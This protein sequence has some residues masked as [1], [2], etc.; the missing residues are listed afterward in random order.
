MDTEIDTNNK[1]FI[2]ARRPNGLGDNL[3][4][5]ALC[6][7]L[8]KYQGKDLII[9][10]QKTA[11]HCHVF[12]DN[13]FP[14]VFNKSN[15]HGVQIFEPHDFPGVYE[16]Q[17]KPKYYNKYSAMMLKDFKFKNTLL[18]NKDYFAHAF[19]GKLKIKPE[20]QIDINEFYQKNL[21]N[22]YIISVHFRFGDHGSL[23]RR[24]T[25]KILN[26]SGKNTKRQIVENAVKLY[27]KKIDEIKKFHKDALVLIFT[28]CE[29]F[30][31]ILLEIYNCIDTASEYPKDGQ[32]F[33]ISKFKT[34]YEKIRESVYLTWLMKS[35]SDFLLYNQSNFNELPRLFIKNQIKIF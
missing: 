18:N 1:G 6:W 9:D 29:L 34:P 11:Y 21:L 7:Y 10:W 14:M 22:K 5:L 33:H 20:I 32:A 24:S 31:N 13:L 3:G 27:S 35:H 25:A 23:A 19:F 30:S 28:D 26:P 12:G 16:Q 2:V 17:I 4:N 8:A 15:I